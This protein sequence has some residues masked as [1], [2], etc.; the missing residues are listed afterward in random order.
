MHMRVLIVDDDPVILHL[1]EAVLQ[2]LGHEVTCRDKALGTTSVI[3]DEQPDVALID[4]EMPGLPGD[5]IVRIA[6]TARFAERCQNTA[7][8]YYSGREPDELE[9]LVAETGVAG[10]ISKLGGP[11]R[12]AE[13]FTE[14]VSKL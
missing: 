13:Q 12:L 2:G 6:R 7:F 3:Y 4:I 9:R 10:A 8:I 11:K 5:E 1:A 14:I